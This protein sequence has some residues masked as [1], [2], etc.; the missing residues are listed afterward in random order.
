MS[1]HSGYGADG[2]PKDRG[3]LPLRGQRRPCSS[4]APASRLMRTLRSCTPGRIRKRAN[5]TAGAGETQADEWPQG[6]PA[7]VV[8]EQSRVP[9]LLTGCAKNAM[10][11]RAAGCL[12]FGADVWTAALG[13]K[14]Q[15]AVPTVA[16]RRWHVRWPAPTFMKT[17][18]QSADR[19]AHC[20]D[21]VHGSAPECARAS[22][23]RG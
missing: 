22:P 9:G 23:R 17:P 14:P 21:A 7:P 6:P 3:R 19:F 10:E 8:S 12:A 16:K 1:E 11:L 20:P 13:S 5:L 15:E 4:S 2:D 18:R